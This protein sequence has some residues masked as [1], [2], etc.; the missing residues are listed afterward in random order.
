MH[1]MAKL[2]A[3]IRLLEQA[4][5][6]AEEFGDGA[7]PRH[8]LCSENK[9]TRLLPLLRALAQHKV[10]RIRAVCRNCIGVCF[11]PL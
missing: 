6:A 3:G 1:H 9:S 4:L 10:A 11:D 7:K 2:N 5:A 8:R